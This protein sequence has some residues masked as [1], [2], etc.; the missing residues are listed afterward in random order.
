MPG[1]RGW[2]LKAL[3][4]LAVAV[5]GGDVE[6]ARLLNAYRPSAEMRLQRAAVLLPVLDDGQVL[7][8]G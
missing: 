1:E 3:E 2:V 4:E 6:G 8:V 5:E 7:H